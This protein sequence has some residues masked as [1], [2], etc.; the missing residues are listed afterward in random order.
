METEIVGYVVVV[1]ISA[2]ISIGITYLVV[3]A[4]TRSALTHHYKMVRW[5][6]KTGVWEHKMSYWKDQPRAF[7]SVKPRSD[8]PRV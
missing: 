2:A 3:R 4:A 6:E 8:D 1:I 5:Y 7:N